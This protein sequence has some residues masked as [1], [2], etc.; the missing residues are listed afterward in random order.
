MCAQLHLEYSAGH[1]SAKLSRGINIII[2]R[3]Q[4]TQNY[5]NKACGAVILIVALMV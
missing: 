1:L 5:E 2:N 4:K 3:N